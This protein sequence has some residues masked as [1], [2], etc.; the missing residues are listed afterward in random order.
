MTTL[1]EFCK[2][3]NLTIKEM[4]SKKGSKTLADFLSAIAEMGLTHQ[5]DLSEFFQEQKNEVKE[6]SHHHLEVS[7]SEVQ[8][9][10]KA[11]VEETITK[12]SNK[13]SQTTFTSIKN[14]VTGE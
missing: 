7:T 10:T 3:R 14:S 1:S 8:P 6:T 2:R 12:K 4:I 9:E 5:E 11:I 13:K